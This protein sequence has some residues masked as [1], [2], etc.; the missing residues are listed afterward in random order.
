ML[1]PGDALV[2][3]LGGLHGFMGWDGPFLTDSG[4][5]QVFSLAALRKLDEDGVRLPEPHR[6]QR[7]T[8]SRPSARWRSS[9]TSAPTSPW[10]S[11]SARRATRPRDGGRR[12]DRAH[13]ALG[14]A[15]PRGAHARRPVAVRHRAGRRPPRPARGERPRARRARLPRLR[16]RRPRRSASRS[17]GATACSS[18]STPL[19]PAERPRYLMGVGTPA[20]P[21]RRRGARHR[22]VR[23]R[24]ADPQRPQRPAVHEPRPALDPQRPLKDDPRP[25]DPDCALPHLPHAPAAPTCATST[26]RARSPRPR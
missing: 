22:H 7:R 14:A 17:R 3:R 12:G 19:L 4:G 16:G 18:S 5:Y 13:H 10:P 15:Q 21:D 2:A 25:P 1:R 23:L 20:G 11:T 26:W 6:R 9:R 24:D 8:C